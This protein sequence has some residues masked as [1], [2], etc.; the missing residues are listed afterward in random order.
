MDTLV[1]RQPVFGRNE[2][3]FGYNLLL[4]TPT[5]GAATQ[6]DGCPEELLVA[7][8]LGIGI[9]R[10]VGGAAVPAF[11]TVD[12]EMLE[13]RI[14]QLFPTN[15]I[16]AQLVGTAAED[17]RTADDCETLLFG[18]YQIALAPTDPWKVPDRLLRAADI[19]KID[20]SQFDL[21]DLAVIAARLRNFQIRPL[22]VNVRHR[23]ERDACIRLGFELFEG[24]RFSSPETLVRR[25]LATETAFTFRV[26]KLVRDPM[27]SDVEIEDI[28][29]R[30]V[31]LTNKLLRMVNSA[32]V[33]GRE[34]WSIGHALR[35]LGRDQVARWLNLILV[36]DRPRHGVGG[37]LI[38]LALVRARLGEL[39]ATASGIPRAAGSLFL[40]GLLSPLDQLL[41]TPME[42]LVAQLELAP[43]VRLA[44]LHREDFY[45]AVLALIEAH[46]LGS[47]EEVDGWAQ[48]VGVSPA[49]V[50][51]LY[52]EALEWAAGQR[53]Q[54][55]QKPP[56][57][58]RAS[59]TRVR[60]R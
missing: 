35:V 22:A 13:S 37:E 16:I 9:D 26:L 43:D 23:S 54:P 7:A 2:Q 12:R 55:P 58:A 32:A 8:V 1:A 56:V 14:V 52:V 36:T 46:E 15:R 4:R 25:D 3:L 27:S 57:E 53:Q 42:T 33:G 50:G 30:D 6:A 38:Q 40:V 29:G 24:Y 59:A 47:W 41:E 45:G 39:L 60:A 10:L 21:V 34:I 48:V 19:V 11:L 49:T 28:L 20:V 31:S 44:L 17:E 5:T 18:C 51:A